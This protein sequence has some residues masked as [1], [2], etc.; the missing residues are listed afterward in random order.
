VLNPAG[1]GVVH[2][3]SLTSTQQT[4]LST[5]LRDASVRFLSQ[6]NG[7]YFFKDFDVLQ[8][9]CG[10][11]TSVCLTT[12]PGS[13]SSADLDWDC[14]TVS[15]P[16]GLWTGS[17]GQVLAHEWGHCCF[18]FQDEYSGNPNGDSSQDFCGHTRMNNL[19]GSNT[20]CTDLNHCK[21]SRFPV[22]GCSNIPS[23]WAQ[24]Q[25][26]GV[27]PYGTQFSPSSTPDPTK[28]TSNSQLKNLITV[29]FR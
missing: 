1:S 13:V 22:Q 14:S 18:N 25:S 8:S 28:H 24:M 4:Q 21:D 9:S 2:P 26:H 5:N 16:Q 29:T 17:S 27:V 10:T 20:L 19:S 11:L 7:N 23:N 6:T 3:F 15:Y 12:N